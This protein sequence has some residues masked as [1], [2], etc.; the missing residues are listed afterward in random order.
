MPCY[1]Q[2]SGFKQNGAAAAPNNLSRAY[3]LV[4]EGMGYPDSSG[5]SGSFS[6]A[7]VTTA[8]TITARGMDWYSTVPKNL[9][10][11]AAYHYGTLMFTKEC[12]PGT[13]VQA[14]GVVYFV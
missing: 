11:N 3:D 1:L 8:L 6:F 12:P 13:P 5:V 14:Y 7:G 4:V 9:F 10:S 2:I